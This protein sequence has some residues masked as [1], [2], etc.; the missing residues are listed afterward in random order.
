[1]KEAR[2][3]QRFLEP[4]Y[5]AIPSG[6]LCIQP[7]TPPPVRQ[8]VTDLFIANYLNDPSGHP[9]ATL[10]LTQSVAGIQIT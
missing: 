6:F 5:V 2:C 1:M 7:F 8:N 10:V 3:D 4:V 9:L